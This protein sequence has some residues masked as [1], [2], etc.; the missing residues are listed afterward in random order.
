MSW[1]LI[2]TN[3]YVYKN[4]DDESDFNG[5]ISNSNVSEEEKEKW[6]SKETTEGAQEKINKA[7][8]SAKEYTDEALKSAKDYTDKVISELEF[9]KEDPKE[10]PATPQ[11]QNLISEEDSNKFRHAVKGVN[12][13]VFEAFQEYYEVPEWGV[14]NAT[15]FNLSGTRNSKHIG[16]HDLESISETEAGKTYTFSMYVKQLRGE[17]GG[18]PQ[19]LTLKIKGLDVKNDTLGIDNDFSGRV[20]VTGIRNNERLEI[21]YH[22]AYVNWHVEVVAFGMKLEEGEETTQYG[23]VLDGHEGDRKNPHSVT[24]DQVG[25]G[26]V[27]NYNIATIDEAIEGVHTEKYMTPALVKR[28][29]IANG[30]NGEGAIKDTN[31]AL[32]ILDSKLLITVGE[33]G[34]YNTLNGALSYASRFVPAYKKA[35]KTSEFNFE[36]NLIEIK[37]LSGFYMQEQVIIEGGLKLGHILITAEDKTVPVKR[38]ALTEYTSAETRP[39]FSGHHNVELPYINAHFTIDNQPAEGVSV[40]ERT[41]G[42]QVVGNSS[43]SVG[44]N[45]GVNGA[46][47]GL[48]VNGGSF[49]YTRFSTFEHNG[50][51]MRVSQS[52][53]VSGRNMRMKYNK[54]GGYIAQACHVDLRESDLS[55]CGSPFSINQG[56]IVDFQDGIANNYETRG[57][58]VMH[59]TLTAIGASFKQDKK[60]DKTIG[61]WVD[62]G[63][64]DL[65]RAQVYNNNNREDIRCKESGIVHL[66]RCRTTNSVK[67][68]NTWNPAIKDTSHVEFNVVDKHRGGIIYGRVEGMVN[69]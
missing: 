62:G 37:I 38:S 55:Y 10:D 4:I 64:V 41:A 28:S 12:G 27:K 6:N 30:G 8:K 5:G 63:T 7:L 67:T 48:Y 46:G 68:G 44:R 47:K 52:S 56:S 9:P 34:D 54:V 36:N 58:T 16:T 32:K 51:G 3:K 31:D 25:L 45:G 39:V 50:R 35:G 1:Q 11:R 60:S 59:A 61:I 33:N 13:S 19:L 49:A 40:D 69:F 15:K 57:A 43:V 42:I 65:S 14:S 22:S 2:E 66:W 24:K 26:N 20:K 18:N 21:Q 29:I 23:D 17:V 53:K